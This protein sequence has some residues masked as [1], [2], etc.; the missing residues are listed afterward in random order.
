MS[1]L[2]LGASQ[3]LNSLTINYADEGTQGVDL[4]SKET[5]FHAL[6]IHGG[7]L[8]GAKSALAAGIQNA[9]IN[10][11]GIYDSGLHASSAIGI[12]K[13]TDA[14]GDDYVLIRPTRIGDLNL[15][16]AVTI[17]DFIDLASHFNAAGDWQAGDLNGDGVVT[18]SDFIDLA[19]NFNT[20][21]AGAALPISTADQLA[22]NAFARAHGVSLVPEPG[23]LAIF[24]AGVCLLRRRRRL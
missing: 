15:D 9:K 21:Y 10:G 2:T 23:S 14:H 20:S 8:A 3:D 12:A 24:F 1:T 5:E 16:G 6:R 4:N 18:I 13:L 22:L 19:S 17:S 11:E 7:D